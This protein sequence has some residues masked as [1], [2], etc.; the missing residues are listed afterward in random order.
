MAVNELEA[1]LEKKIKALDVKLAFQS[2]AL[3][4]LSAR[5]LSKSQVRGIVETTLLPL[6]DII[7]PVGTIIQTVN[8]VNPMT[9]G[10]HGTWTEV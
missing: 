6:E 1:R 7:L 5:S 3:N 4:Y 2:K 8:D 9:L 10:F